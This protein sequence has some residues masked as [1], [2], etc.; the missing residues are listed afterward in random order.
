M[1]WAS[2]EFDTIEL[3]DKR[4]D[5]RAVLLAERMAANPTKSIPGACHS[6][7]EIQ[8]AYRFIKNDSVGFWQIINN[9][10]NLRLT[11]RSGSVGVAGSS[12]SSMVCVRPAW[13][14]MN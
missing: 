1:G 10:A 12:Y 7:A 3:S 4:L 11:R 2:E 6:W 14:G 9:E 5:K 13:M 8:A